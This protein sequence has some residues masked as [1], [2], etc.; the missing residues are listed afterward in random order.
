MSPIE[1]GPRDADII[2]RYDLMEKLGVFPHNASTSSPLVVEEKVFVGTGNGM[3]WTHTNIPSPSSPTLIALDRNTGRLVGEDDANI[4]P[5]I[6]H[7]SWGSPSAGAV[8]GRQLVFFGGPD[9]WCYAFDAKP[10]PGE[11]DL[12]F[13]K[14]A[15]KVDCNPPEY[16]VKD[17]KP[18]RYTA[19]A[20]IS[21]II[22][23]PVFYLIASMSPPGKI[24]NTV[25]G[26]ATWSALT[27]RR[28]VTS[29]KR[30]SSGGTSRSN[31]PFRS[32]R[33]IQ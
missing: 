24:P 7:G 14:T 11:D 30:E 5:R 15:W 18:I 33:S 4:G 21:E 2:W 29:R 6:L 25:R 22:A 19:A 23:T 8:F 28:A 1:P 12:N 13:L 32:F 9:G 10:S 27:P 31:V 20:G 16:K 26:S 3:D 17:G